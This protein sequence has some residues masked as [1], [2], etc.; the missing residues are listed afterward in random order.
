MWLNK[1]K[2]RWIKMS[3]VYCHYCDKHIDTD[4]DAEHF[5][6]QFKEFKCIIQEIDSIKEYCLKR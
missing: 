1:L 2:K 5:D 6:T 4:F 3:I